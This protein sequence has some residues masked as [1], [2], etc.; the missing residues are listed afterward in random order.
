ML[1]PL[2]AERPQIINETD[3]GRVMN[4]RDIPY[5]LRQAVNSPKTAQ[6]T[7]LQE[8]KKGRRVSSNT[9]RERSLSHRD[10]VSGNYLI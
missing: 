8:A 2:S 7:G 3:R 10:T 9:Q 6:A 5:R 4:G 1:F